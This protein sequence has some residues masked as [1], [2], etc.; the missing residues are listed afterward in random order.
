MPT[1]ANPLGQL[2]ADAARADGPAASVAVR[3]RPGARVETA[4]VV[5]GPV[6]AIMTA[7]HDGHQLI[8]RLMLPLRQHLAWPDEETLEAGPEPDQRVPFAHLA[9]QVGRYAAGAS[10]RGRLQAAPRTGLPGP[11]T[12]ANNG[13]APTNPLIVFVRP[14]RC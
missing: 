3:R 13:Q 12:C 14:G 2:L 8:S 1:A 10:W 6:I 4:T 11:A 5:P 9:H 7:S